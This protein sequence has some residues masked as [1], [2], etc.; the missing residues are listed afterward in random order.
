MDDSLGSK[1]ARS[2]IAAYFV[3]IRERT[4]HYSESSVVA[5]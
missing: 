2:G 3:H 1:V 5:K 4:V